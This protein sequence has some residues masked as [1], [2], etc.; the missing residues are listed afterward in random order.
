[1]KLSTIQKEELETVS[2]PDGK[3]AYILDVGQDDALLMLISDKEVNEQQ[4][5]ECL[6]ENDVPI[7]YPDGINMTKLGD[8]DV[9]I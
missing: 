7:Y 5:I 4:A 8:V 2:V 1:M 9:D 3:Y 6:K